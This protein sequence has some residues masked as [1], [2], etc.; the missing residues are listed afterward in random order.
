MIEDDLNTIGSA[1][2]M[3]HRFPH[4]VIGNN[5]IALKE[6][7]RYMESK[8]Q[9]VKIVTTTLNRTSQEATKYI[10]QEI[11]KYTTLNLKHQP[12]RPF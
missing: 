6:A 4:H 9:K 11:Q 3:H 10:T 8:V 7:K 12:C 2:M 1:P 5:T